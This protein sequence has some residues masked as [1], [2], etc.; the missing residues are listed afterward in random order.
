VTSGQVSNNLKANFYN[1]YGAYS[2]AAQ[3]FLWF[4]PGT[5]SGPFLWLDSYINQIYM[6]AQFQ[7]DLME[8][9]G[10]VL[11][12]PYN[13]TGYAQIE[14]ACMDTIT[15]MVNFGAIRVGVTLS[16]L[17]TTEVISQ[18]GLA[19]VPQALTNQGWFFQVQPATVAVR[20][21][22]ASPVCLFLYTDG[23][24]VQNIT[25]SSILLL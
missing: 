19:N 9:F 18:T 16:S 20:Q 25:L 1:W 2:T 4:Y 5:V 12:I 23:Q 17:E 7:L 3:Q 15:Q 13:A 22:R 14:A 11:S 21:A 10:Q 24:S 6:N 8:L